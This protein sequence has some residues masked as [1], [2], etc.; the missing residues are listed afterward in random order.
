MWGRG[1]GRLVR[2]L[3]ARRLR[4]IPDEFDRAAAAE[5][6]SRREE[7]ASCARDDRSRSGDGWRWELRAHSAFCGLGYPRRP[8]LDYHMGRLL[9]T[10][11]RGRVIKADLS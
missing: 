9:S 1:P 5:R 3:S 8:T 10:T 7:G 4:E 2:Q 6:L 11:G